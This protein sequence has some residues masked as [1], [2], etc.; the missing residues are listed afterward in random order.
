MSRRAGLSF[1]VDVI[2]ILV[3]VALGR[4]SHDEDGG[5][6]GGLVQVAAPFLLALVLGWVALRAWRRPMDPATGVGLWLVVVVLG[7]LLRRVVFDR[8]T[9]TPFVIVATLFIGVLLIGWR[10]VAEHLET[11]RAA[12]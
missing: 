7:M 11:R 9:A 3:F 4:Q 12:S 2:A 1:L 5:W 6:L 8:G 10:L